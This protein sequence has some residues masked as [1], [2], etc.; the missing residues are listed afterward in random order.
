MALELILDSVDTLPEAVRG[1]YVES[2]G[3][4]KLDVAGIPD[5]TGLKTA[6]D[7][8]RK[9]AKAANAKAA[10]Y[11]KRFAGIDP[12]E[13]AALKAE[14]EAME[15]ARLKSE[16]KL[17]EVTAKRLE[18]AKAEYQKMADDATAQRDAERARANNFEA[19]VL[20]S[21]IM[22]AATGK[23][24]AD[25]ATMDVVAMLAKSVFSLNDNGDAVAFDQDGNVILG[26]DGKTPYTPSEW[27][28]GLKETHKF[29]FPAGNT[30]GGSQGSRQTIAGNKTMTQEQFHSAYLPRERAAAITSGKITLID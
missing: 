2:E 22:G 8:E 29:L 10:D 6:L 23:V 11:E 19:K 3:K 16:G 30:G 14:R 28:D 17:E 9:A 5:T 21:Q 25:P 4:F 27:L 20:A 1:L 7:A 26:K 13:V 24:H 15:E 12:E 18:K